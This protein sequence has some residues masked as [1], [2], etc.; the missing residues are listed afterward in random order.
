MKTDWQIVLVR[1]GDGINWRWTIGRISHGN[2]TVSGT[3]TDQLATL[4]AANKAI[5]R[6]VNREE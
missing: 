2:K 1:T 5:D 3:A 6:E 4:M